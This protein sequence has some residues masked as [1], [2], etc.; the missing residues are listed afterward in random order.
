MCRQIHILQA[1]KNQFPLRE[2]EHTNL[3]NRVVVYVSR[4]PEQCKHKTRN[5]VQSYREVSMSPTVCHIL[6]AVS[7][8]FLSL[9]SRSPLTNPA[10]TRG[11]GPDQA[12]TP[13]SPTLFVI[14][15]MDAAIAPSD[16]PGRHHVSI[17]GSPVRLHLDFHL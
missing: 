4:L 11:F 16:R 8:S 2:V 5:D 1:A 13:I 7:L 10:S 14:L 15:P 17:V 12:Y 6:L 3:H 9:T